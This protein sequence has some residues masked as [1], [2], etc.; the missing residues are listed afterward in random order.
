MSKSLRQARRTLRASK[1]MWGVG[2][3]VSGM[4]GEVGGR[5]E[6]TGSSDIGG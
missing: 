4:E 5:R 6:R 2:E 3:R 1:K